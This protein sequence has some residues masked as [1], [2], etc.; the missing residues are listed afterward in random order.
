MQ[1]RVAISASPQVCGADT[2][3]ECWT[4]G[5][6]LGTCLASSPKSC[7][8]HV[9][10]CLSL[11]LAGFSLIWNGL[12]SPQIAKSLLMVWDQQWK[13]KI[14]KVSAVP[15]CMW[16]LANRCFQISC[17]RCFTFLVVSEANESREKQL[18][19]LEGKETLRDV[20]QI[21]GKESLTISAVHRLA[22]VFGCFFLLWKFWIVMF[23]CLFVFWL[24]LFNFKSC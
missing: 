8:T 5:M 11:L 16:L 24:I 23:V 6:V 19:L 9:L 10:E 18:L 7:V 17:N 13:K 14:K 4:K 1:Y 21:H 15:Q 22:R 3:M 2:H 12:Q 20:S